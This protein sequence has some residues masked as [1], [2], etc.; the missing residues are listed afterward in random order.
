MKKMFS[1]Y[2]F[3]FFIL[4]ESCINK[5]LKSQK[6][7]NSLHFIHNDYLKYVVT[8]VSDR[9]SVSG[10]IY[11][12]GT[13]VIT[14]LSESQRE[15]VKKIDKNTWLV[16]LNNPNTDWAANLVLYELHQRYAGRLVGLNRDKW[17]KNYGKEVDIDFWYQTL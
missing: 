11:T 8:R 13:F 12:R 10:L 9:D 2:I 7:P 15:I 6:I 5:Q 4:T 17:L 1:I 16:L 3:T 14:R